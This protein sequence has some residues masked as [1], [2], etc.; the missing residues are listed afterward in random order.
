M[1]GF[2]PEKLFW[3]HLYKSNVRFHI[4]AYLQSRNRDTVLENKRYGHQ[5][6]KGGM[7]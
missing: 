6:G 2:P 7:G 4:Y 3:L 5:G 1:S